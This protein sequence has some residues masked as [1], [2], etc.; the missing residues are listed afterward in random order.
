MTCGLG[1]EQYFWCDLCCAYS[2]DR[3]RKLARPCDRIHRTVNAVNKLR[4]SLQPLLGTPL[5]TS[6]RRMLK[7]DVGTQ[8]SL[9]DPLLSIHSADVQVTFEGGYEDHRTVITDVL[10]CPMHNPPE[11]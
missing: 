8:L 10:A 4:D 9:L 11:E 7:A 5:A 6:A 2:G 3:V 1:Q